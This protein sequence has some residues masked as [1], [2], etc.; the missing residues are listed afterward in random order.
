MPNNKEYDN[1]NRGT[2]FRNY[3]K[4]RMANERDTSK[5]ANAQGSLDV[6]GMKFYISAWTQVIKSG[7]NKGDKFQSLSI[8]PADEAEG[9]KLEAA[10]KQIVNGGNPAA[11]NNLKKNKSKSAEIPDEFDDMDDDL[12]F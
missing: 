9:A 7:D 1:T 11:K 12:P 4:E 10:I 2:L 8:K 5:W 3:D 6:Y